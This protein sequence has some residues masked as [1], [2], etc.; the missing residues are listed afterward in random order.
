M[1]ALT[2]LLP[3][4]SSRTRI[5]ARIVPKIALRT[6]TISE[7]MTVSSSAA[8]ASGE[9]TWSQKVAEAAGEGFAGDRRQRQQHD[10]AQVEHDHAAAEADA[11]TR[12]GELD[13]APGCRHGAG[14][15]PGAPPSA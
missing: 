7:Q 9:V 10:Q 6:T 11:E 2:R 14:R 5:Q 1:T 15:L 4:N 3:G 13:L 8:I 12:A